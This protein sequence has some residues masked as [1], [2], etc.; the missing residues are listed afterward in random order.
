MHKAAFVCRFDLERDRNVSQHEYDEI[1]LN[2]F[3]GDFA[4]SYILEINSITSLQ[5]IETL[6]RNDF[7]FMQ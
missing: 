6:G 5:P 3:R 2:K 4:F 7:K 1:Y